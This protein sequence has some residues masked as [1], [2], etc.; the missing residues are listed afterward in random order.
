MLVKYKHQFPLRVAESPHLCN[1]TSTLNQICSPI[2]PP[3]PHTSCTLSILFNI[4]LLSVFYLSHGL[5]LA[6]SL[7]KV[8]MDSMFLPMCGL[9]PIITHPDSC[10][11]LCLPSNIILGYFIVVSGFVRQDNLAQLNPRK[12]LYYH[13][14]KL[15]HPTC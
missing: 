1:N 4:S 8:C 7:R 3:T 10:H 2:L 6:C 11:F 15:P 13:S 5:F 12:I 9:T 14:T